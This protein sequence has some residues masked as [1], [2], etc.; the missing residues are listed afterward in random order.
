MT[1]FLMIIRS[2]LNTVGKNSTIIIRIIPGR[3]KPQ[4][5]ICNP[6]GGWLYFYNTSVNNW[7]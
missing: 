1:N 5:R 3:V 7:V 2:V 4:P 6:L